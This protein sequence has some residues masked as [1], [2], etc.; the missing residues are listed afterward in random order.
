LV[1]ANRYAFYRRTV[2]VRTVW[3]L[4]AGAS[5]AAYCGMPLVNDFMG[6]A[7]H[8]LRLS[9][10]QGSRLLNFIRETY[11]YEEPKDV[12]VEELLTFAWCDVSH[13]DNQRDSPLPEPEQLRLVH[14]LD[15]L[16]KVEA[17]IVAVLCQAQRE[18]IQTGDR[19]HGPLAERVE[20]EDT[21][22]SYNYDLLFDHALWKAKKASSD[23]YGL[24]FNDAVDGSPGPS[25]REAYRRE[26]E[27]QLGCQGVREGV[28]VLKLHGSLNWLGLEH[29]NLSKRDPEIFYLPEAI[30]FSV[31][32]DFWWT[33]FGSLRPANSRNDTSQF[34]RLRPIIVPPTFAKDALK[35]SPM[36]KLW[37]KA[38]EALEKCDRVVIIGLS[39]RE[40]D[41]QTRWLLRAALAAARPRDIEI[42]VV[43]PSSED[44]NRLRG[45]FLGLGRVVP[46]ESIE[47][48]LDG[49]PTT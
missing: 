48:F 20:I 40:A 31:G 37:P 44:R 27:I 1:R 16:R 32:P 24:A 49:R 22:I 8:R 43:N 21:V 11:G 30:N 42:D 29:A 45:F 17:L 46:Y 28:P 19:V 3:I 18:C 36:G 34:G 47:K 26:P 10:N 9:G 41:Y 39:V 5:K 35:G 23:D 4:G 15:T 38:K 13:L 25:V 12:N 33:G 2:G 7:F 14:A 6:E